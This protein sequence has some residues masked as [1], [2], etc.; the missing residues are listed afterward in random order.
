MRADLDEEVR[1]MLKGADLYCTEARI[2]I[3]KVLVQAPSP[4]QQNEIAARLASKTLNKVTIY[5]TLQSLV[6][7]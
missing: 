6:E 1:R 3:L 5:R 2:A 4:L 7:A